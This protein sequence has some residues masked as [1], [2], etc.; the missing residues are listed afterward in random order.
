MRCAYQPR[1]SITTQTA[2]G[3]TATTPL[4]ALIAC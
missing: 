3:W 2:Y 4:S 1:L